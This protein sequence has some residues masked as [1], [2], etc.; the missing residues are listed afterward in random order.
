M[1]LFE[2][3]DKNAKDVTSVSIVTAKP[4]PTCC[5]DMFH[6]W[7]Q[8]GCWKDSSTSAPYLLWTAARRH[9]AAR[10][11]GRSWL[12]VNEFSGS[13]SPSRRSWGCIK[14]H[15]K[16]RQV[17]KV[18]GK[19]MLTHASD[20]STDT[21]DSSEDHTIQT[22]HRVSWVL[23]CHH[24]AQLGGPYVRNSAPTVTAYSLIISFPT[25]IKIKKHLFSI[26]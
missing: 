24:K 22:P 21:G 6:V 10:Q 4:P 23:S 18:S 11:G 15:S 14:G 13:F 8:H 19:P 17:N 12:A 9:M 25:I 2:R 20:F 5:R 7:L 1:Q 3:A 16:H 26:P